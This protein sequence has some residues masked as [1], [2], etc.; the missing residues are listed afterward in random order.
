MLH[1]RASSM[2]TFIKLFIFKCMQY[3][4]YFRLG[5]RFVCCSDYPSP[6][7]ME[8]LDKNIERNQL[9]RRRIQVVPYIWGD[10]TE[11]MFS[12]NGGHPF[13]MLLAS[14]CLWRHEQVL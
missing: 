10:D 11:A 2:Q 13:D 1:D 12:A 5:A 14:E 3:F 8:N 6:T 7:V 9:D 4:A